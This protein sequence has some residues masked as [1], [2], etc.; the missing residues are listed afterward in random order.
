M[1]KQYTVRELLTISTQYLQEKGCASARLDAELLL[2]HVL[3]MS[4]IDLYLNLDKPLTSKEVDAYRACIG[5]RGRREPVAYITG[6]KEFYSL[7]F[8][9]TPAVLIPRPETELLVDKVVLLAQ[10]RLQAGQ[11]EVRIL[12][13]GTGSG[14]VAV[15][16]ARQDPAF[17]ITAVDISPAALEVARKN[18]ERHEVESQIQFLLSN[19]FAAVEGKFDIICSN[20]PYLSQAE[21][22]GLQPEITFEPAQAL[23]GGRDGLAYYRRIFQ[24]APA[25]LAKPGRIVVEIGAQQGRAVAEIAQSSGFTV[26]ECLKDYGGHDRVVV[27]RWE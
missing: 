5:R 8:R 4:R 23:D 22:A 20:P 21:M 25:Y 13:L 24:S 1:K 11:A 10:A 6:T 19:L 16:V 15:A 27:A 2:A 7:A 12:E 14:A 9:V 17:S 26:E 18:A 3:E